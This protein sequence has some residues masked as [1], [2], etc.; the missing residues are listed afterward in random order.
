MVRW[1]LFM[2]N[3]E[4]WSRLL[5][6]QVLPL[7]TASPLPPSSPSGRRRA[8][9]FDKDRSLGV[10]VRLVGD[11]WSTVLL[12]RNHIKFWTAWTL[13]LLS[14]CEVMISLKLTNLKDLKDFGV[15]VR[16]Q[17]KYVQ[18]CGIKSQKSRMK[19]TISFTNKLYRELHLDIIKMLSRLFL[20]LNFTPN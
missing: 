17:L 7:L 20:K 18:G 4:A 13:T 5:H 2:S 11:T 1:A 10:E 9:H 3:L 8:F 6:S 19:N 16:L 12:Q 14:V 15:T